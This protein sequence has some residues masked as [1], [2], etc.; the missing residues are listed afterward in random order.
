MC[1]SISETDTFTCSNDSITY[2]INHKLDCN[3]KC[4]IYLM[5]CK[6]CFKQHVVQTVDTFRGRRNNSKDNARKFEKGQHC[7]AKTFISTFRLSW[8]H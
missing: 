3:E 7:I 6:K 8:L 1:Q 4:L 5:T 2:K